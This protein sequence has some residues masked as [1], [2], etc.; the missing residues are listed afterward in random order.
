MAIQTSILSK[1]SSNEQRLERAKCAMIQVVSDWVAD[2]QND[3]S[4]LAR[5]VDQEV[6]SKNAVPTTA[7]GE[8]LPPFQRDA[9]YIDDLVE[10][11]GRY[12][13]GNI[14]QKHKEVVGSPSEKLSELFERMDAA[15]ENFSE[16]ISHGQ[17]PD[18]SNIP[19]GATRQAFSDMIEAAK[20][21]A[22][23]AY[24]ASF[25]SGDIAKQ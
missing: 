1:G 22:T 14:N 23:D 5:L 6:S 24:Q 16:L 13:S 18:G 12:L 17:H 15:E 11:V 4:E 19:L 9:Y 25:K 2:L 7:T 3:E 21:A 10:E 20:E 8:S